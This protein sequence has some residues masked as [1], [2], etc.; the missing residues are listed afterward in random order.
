[1][2]ASVYYSIAGHIL[3]IEGDKVCDLLNHSMYGFSVFE[4]ENTKYEWQIVFNDNV[5]RPEEW[6]E[7]Y[8]CTF[9]VG[10]MMGTLAKV[11]DTYY[12]AM[13]P[14]DDS[15]VSPLIMRYSFGSDTLEATGYV[16]PVNLRFALWMA[17]GMLSMN[18]KMLLIHSSCVVH[19][20][21][22]VLCLGESGT[23]KSTHTRLWLK[24]IPDS[25]LLND[26]SP[27]LAFENGEAVVYGSPWS[28]KTHCY[29]QKR[30]PL[31]AAIRLSQAP[32]NKIRRL[33]IVESLSALHPSC[34]PALAQDDRYQDF[35]VELL[36]DVLGCVPVY[37]LECL[38]DEA[39]AWTSHDAIFGPV[40]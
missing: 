19:Q 20:N 15:D 3:R 21:K 40:K 22:A 34:P 36:S 18:S 14:L 33:G 1:M 16:S 26:D 35:I 13:D 28:G 2:A 29:H 24:Y 9:D 11:G 37:H 6:T 38:P 32:Y 7:L 27:V 23:G 31:A 8:S 25:H 10:N 4:T 12:F 5:T 30:F 39:A 17:T